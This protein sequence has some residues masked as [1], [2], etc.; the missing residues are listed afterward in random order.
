MRGVQV[1]AGIGSGGLLAASLVLGAPASARDTVNGTG[2]DDRLRGTAFSD[3]I[4][5]FGGNDRVHA[6]AGADVIFGGRGSDGVVAG[7]GAD[8]VRGGNADDFLDGGQG[9]DTI[10]GRGGQDG[11]AGGAGSDVIFGGSTGDFL[12]RDG[13]GT[14]TIHGG[15]GDDYFDLAKDQTRDTVTC[16]P[17]HDQVWGATPGENTI[18]A[19]CEEIHVKPFTCGG[20][21]VPQRPGHAAAGTPTSSRTRPLRSLNRSAI[22]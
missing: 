3:T 10:R 15:L 11:I 7:R 22:R 1:L 16:G 17:G 21:R 9:A 6:L 14:D 4:R 18:A 12:L 2:G 8:T 20:C 19:D 13:D 5:G